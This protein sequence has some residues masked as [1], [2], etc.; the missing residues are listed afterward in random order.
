MRPLTAIGDVH[1]RTL[2]QVLAA[3]FRTLAPVSPSTACSRLPAPM[4]HTNAAL[5]NLPTRHVPVPPAL[6]PIAAPQDSTQAAQQKPLTAEEQMILMELERERSK[7]QVQ[8]GS[9]PPLPP[10]P[11]APQ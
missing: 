4:Y 9:M 11:I 2:V 5:R 8:N 3:L 7:G 6:T 10:T 1:C